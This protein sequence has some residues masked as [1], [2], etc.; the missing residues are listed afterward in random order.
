MINLD[1][2]GMMPIEIQKEI[3]RKEKERRREKGITQEEMA[4][5]ANLSLSSLRRFEQTGEISFAALIRIG[6]VLDD[7]KAFLGLFAPQEF[8]TMKELLDAKR[9]KG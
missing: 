7:E 6:S 4:R 9:R 8:R 1:E 2:F 5:R 3:A